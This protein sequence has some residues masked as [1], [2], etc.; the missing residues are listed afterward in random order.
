M[1]TIDI[2]KKDLESLAGKKFTHKELEDALL[3]VKGEIDS[4]DGDT[5][6]VDVKETNRPDLWSTEGVARE[7]RARM[8]IRRGIPQYRAAKGNL[9]IVIEKSVKEVRPL[10]VGAVV[11][12]LKITEPLLLQMIQLQEKIHATYGRKRKEAAMGV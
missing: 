7:L 10:T 5:I 9:K 3:Y 12:G 11:R 1:P 2:S 6:K 8:G 4:Q